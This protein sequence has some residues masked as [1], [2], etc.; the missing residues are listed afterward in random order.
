MPLVEVSVDR[1]R[2]K[3]GDVRRR[4]S[5]GLESAMRSGENEATNE[6]PVDTGRLKNAVETIQITRFHYILVANTHYAPFVEFGTAPH[7]IRANDAQA[8]FWK[9]ADHP[10]KAVNH[11]GTPEQPFMR[12]ARDRIAQVLP[13]KIDMALKGKI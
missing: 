2:M 12:P 11:P 3:R 5:R 4:L 9:G 6:V 10:V 1:D 7:T 13:R 8:L